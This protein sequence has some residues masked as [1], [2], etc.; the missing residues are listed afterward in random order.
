MEFNKHFCKWDNHYSN[1]LNSLICLSAAC[2]C[3]QA[4]D[5]R[6]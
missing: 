1:I 3:E 6:A 5:K 2:G 4:A